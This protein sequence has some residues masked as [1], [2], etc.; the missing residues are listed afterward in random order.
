MSL[1][2]GDFYRY[3]ESV[4]YYWQW[5]LC[6]VLWKWV[7]FTLKINSIETII[8]EYL[9]INRSD[10]AYFDG[11]NETIISVGLVKPKPGIFQ[12]YVKYLLILTT[13]VEITVLGVTLT[14]TKNGKIWINSNI[15]VNCLNIIYSL[16]K[17]YLVIQGSQGEIQLVPEPIF[18][19]ATDGVA[20]TTIANTNSGRIFLG[21]RNGSLYEIYYQVRRKIIWW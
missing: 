6:L 17:K 5:H 14:E 13:T 9:I 2:D 4:A 11:L 12:S 19:V 16:L 15:K 1:H 8:T 3:F 20:I 7:C 21:G 10:V 18:T